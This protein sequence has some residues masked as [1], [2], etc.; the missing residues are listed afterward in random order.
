[1]RRSDLSCTV[2]VVLPLFAILSTV[3]AL[4]EY[5]TV[6]CSALPDDSLPSPVF[7]TLREAMEYLGTK[8]RKESHSVDVYGTCQESAN[9][10][11]Q[12]YSQIS[13]VGKTD[14]AQISVESG[15]SEVL[16]FW[17]SSASLEDLTLVG[18]GTAVSA[19]GDGQI[20]FRRCV[21]RN[22]KTGVSAA[23]GASIGLSGTRIQNTGTTALRVDSGATA[24]LFPERP[25]GTV[26][27]TTLTNDVT[28]GFGIVVGGL[29]RLTSG[30]TIT[31]FGAG[32]VCHGGR[33]DFYSDGLPI[34]ITGNRYGVDGEEGCY[35]SMNGPVAVSD[36]S[37][38]GLWLA[39]STAVSQW[40]IGP[41]SIE[42][43]GTE[44]A[45]YSV[46]IFAGYGSYLSLADASISENLGTGLILDSSS[47][48]RLV[49]SRVE[50]NAGKG[51][52]V[53][54][55]CAADL[56]VGNE[57]GG[58]GDTDLYCTR[59]GMGRGDLSK[60]DKIACPGTGR[61]T[62]STGRDD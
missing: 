11:I 60:V 54:D 56:L 20:D 55:F 26:N 8:D 25:G 4:G 34:S 12:G 31:G 10:W 48:I 36:N 17:N 13:I 41:Q 39:H 33:L 24:V 46:G 57:V 14:P 47:N 42:R 6:N 29:V 53:K 22:A 43:N 50:D 18:G 5:V 30:T 21:I 1:M 27:P 45:S 62:I 61:R 3:P 19:G 38:A 59:F 49:N 23:Q 9:Q 35:L 40:G 51:I 52:H 37:V 2:L 15:T 16:A 58:N 44:G 28:H 7:K 32:I